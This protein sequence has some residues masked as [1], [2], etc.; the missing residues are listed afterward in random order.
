[1]KKKW[2]YRKCMASA[3]AFLLVL[4]MCLSPV[5]A[6]GTLAEEKA[7]ATGQEEAQDPGQLPAG[8]TSAQGDAEGAQVLPGEYMGAHSH[9]QEENRVGREAAEETA[10]TPQAAPEIKGQEVGELKLVYGDASVPDADAFVLL[11]FGD[12]FTA[13]EQDKFYTEA[14]KTADYVMETSP[15][16]EFKDTIKIY[17]LG[18][19]SKDSG[20]KGDQAKTKEEADADPKE[21]YF[22]ARYWL[23]GMQRLLG[24]EEGSEGE[25]KMNALQA[26]KLPAA[27]HNMLIVNSTV[28]GGS[29]GTICAASL[30]D[31]ALEIMVHEMGHMI[32]SLADEYWAGPSYATEDRVNM[33][34]E[35]DPAKVKWSRFVGKNHVGVYEYTDGG[36]GWYHPGKNCK[37]QFLGKQNPFCEVCKEALRRSIAGK[38]NT[39]NLFFQTYADK[40]YESDT[41]KDMKE[42]FIVRK[43][44]KETT[45]DQLGDALTLEYTDA[46]GTP[47]QGIPSKAGLYTVTAVFS[48]NDTYGPATQTGS[49]TIEL[50]DRITLEAE[51]KEYDGKPAKVTYSVDY[52]KEYTTE[53]HYTGKIPYTDTISQDYDSEEAPT[54]AGS[55]T[56]TVKAFDKET[57]KPVSEKSK[58]FEIRFKKTDLVNN[59]DANY[60]GA[61]VYYNNKAIVITGEGFTAEEQGK[62]EELAKKYVEH[63]QSLEPFKETKHYFNF[64]T[65]EAESKESG[66]GV[67]PPPKDTYFRLTRDAEGKVVPTEESTAAATYIGKKVVTSYYKNVIVI[68]NDEKV[69]QGT[70]SGNTIYVGP[71]EE[72]M[73]FAARAILNRLTGKPSD[74]QPATEE[75][76]AAQRLALL[77]SMY[78]DWYGG[79]YATI[80]SRAYDEIFPANGTAYDLA[81]YFH[82]YVGDKEVPQDQLKFVM[83]YYEDEDGKPGRQLESAPSASGTYHVRAEL[84]PAEGSEYTVVT[85]DGTTY[86]IPPSRGWTTYMIG[87]GDD[88]SDP[89]VDKPGTGNSAST[90]V[91]AGKTTG[92]KAGMGKKTGV[93]KTGDT[94]HYGVYLALMLCAVAA[95]V[96]V[97]FIKRRK[98]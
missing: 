7:P 45:G 32:A 17:A 56:V 21:T 68:V 86:N 66:I 91:P 58:A 52:D 14:T 23:Y 85:V 75:E 71:N 80:V 74:Y 53:V 40:F 29:G 97:F 3:T 89:S 62:F 70:V 28:Y 78:V 15:F 34:Q 50:E 20:A 1:M 19:V 30:A 37:M 90:A 95:G 73:D 35:S 76:K 72:G 88:P 82:A 38:S 27:D 67:A 94:N 33:T 18:T 83:T 39:T 4:C 54:K 16:D 48:G 87:K 8:D 69:K 84:L 96:V 61:A 64:T 98:R 10:G 49:Y 59:D 43:G 93:V 31:S 46:F 92:K 63:I 9:I 79:H 55:Y 65:V 13:E 36:N 41:G 2:S 24:M 42:Y 44:D 25:K 81:P 5:G 11:V 6:I 47:V 26:E 12:G 77:N 51:S 57:G 22:G 60:W